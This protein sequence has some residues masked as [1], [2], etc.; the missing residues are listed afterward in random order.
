MRARTYRLVWVYVIIVLLSGSFGAIQSPQ[1][2][3][4]LGEIGDTIDGVLIALIITFFENMVRDVWAR[5]LRRFKPYNIALVR[6]TVYVATFYSVPE[7][8]DWAMQIILPGRYVAGLV[9]GHHIALYFAFAVAVTVFMSVR[10]MLG[11]KYLLAMATGRYRRPIEEEHIVAFM[12]LKGSTPL[13]ERLGPSRYHDFLND[14]FFDVADAIADT[15]GDVYQYVGD[16]I[17]ITWSTARGLKNGDCVRFLFAVE[18]VLAE[19]RDVY[20]KDYGST[21]ALRGALH[22]GPLMVGEIGD[23]KRQIVMIGDT[24]NTAARIEG[25]CRKFGRDHVASASLL[26]RLA[27]L[28]DFVKAESLGP[29]PLAGKSGE[30]ELFAL[31]RA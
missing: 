23:L 31:V 14:V 1:P 5:E 6:F 20:M 7:I 21:P 13:A 24:M 17:V 3:T 30:M 19:R 16:E 26:V 25:A 12:D 18:D 11:G 27:Q 10:R 29:V 22:I 8:V 28:P 9:G 4:L 2:R 15:G